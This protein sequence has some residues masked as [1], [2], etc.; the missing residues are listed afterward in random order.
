MRFRAAG[1]LRVEAFV[2]PG[3]E[4]G[5]QRAH[6]FDTGSAQH[7]VRC[8]HRRRNGAARHSAN[9]RAR[10]SWAYTLPDTRMSDGI[11]T[12]LHSA[13]TRGPSRLAECLSGNAFLRTVVSVFRCQGRQVVR[14]CLWR[15]EVK[16]RRKVNTLSLHPNPPPRS[17]LS[18]PFLRRD[19]GS[20]SRRWIE[21]A[22]LPDTRNDPEH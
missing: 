2:L 3:T 11:R 15:R 19:K 13:K 1:R 9:G 4:R 12:A 20:G 6:G 14:N 21:T 8:C 5:D 10:F 18:V 16:S 7:A 17:S 22:A